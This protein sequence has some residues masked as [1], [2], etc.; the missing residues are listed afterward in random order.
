MTKTKTIKPELKPEE[1]LN[2][3]LVENNLAIAITGIQFAVG[4]NG[5]LVFGGANIQVVK[6]QKEDTN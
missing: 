3:F 1:M 4:N 2:N 6:K 5:A